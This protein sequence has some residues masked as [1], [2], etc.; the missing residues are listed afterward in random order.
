MTKIAISRLSNCKVDAILKL[1]KNN[2]GSTDKKFFPK[3]HLKE[4]IAYY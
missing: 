3:P 1:L 2:C 4:G